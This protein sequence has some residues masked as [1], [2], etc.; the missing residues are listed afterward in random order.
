MTLLNDAVSGLHSAMDDVLKGI[1]IDGINELLPTFAGDPPSWSSP[2]AH[3]APQ[4]ELLKLK[5]SWHQ[6]IIIGNGFDLECGLASSFASFIEARN[7]EFGRLT[8]K[9]IGEVPF[10]T[11]TIWDEILA[12]ME[13]SNWCDIEGAIAEWISPGKDG[14]IESGFSKTLDKLLN[15][16][17]THDCPGVEDAVALLLNERY[18]DCGEWDSDALHRATRNE[19]TTL[20]SDFGKY[21]AREV[22]NTTDYKNNVGKLMAEIYFDQKPSES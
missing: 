14:C 8:K 11:K 20:E 22:E 18:C 12:S 4:T 2:L 10:F 7:A 6:L 3:V 13:D 21:L 9:Q 15:P 1:N 19:L 16:T 5:P 17:E